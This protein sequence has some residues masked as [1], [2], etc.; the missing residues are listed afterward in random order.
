MTFSAT[1]RR[2]F[3]FASVVTMPS[4]ATSD[5]TRFAIISRW[6]DEL[7]P[8]RRPFFGVP[9]MTASAPA[10]ERQAPLVE[11]GD[12]LVERLLAEVRDGQQVVLA[13]EEQLAHGVDL[14]TLQAV[15]RTLREIEV[16]DGE[17]EVGRRRRGDGD[18]AELEPL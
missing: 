11:L 8:K 14:G 18:L 17:V 2:A 13:L 10:A 5:A 9:C 4:A 12:D 3:A 1:G 15:A 16:L 7:P 6:C